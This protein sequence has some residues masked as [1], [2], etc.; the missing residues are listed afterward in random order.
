[1]IISHEHK[2]IFLKVT[3]TAGTSVEIAL[4]QHCGETDVI[5]PISIGDEKLRRDL[6]YPC[7]QNFRMPFHRYSLRD[8]KKLLRKRKRRMRFYNHMPAVE[9]KRIVG[10]KIWDEYFKFCFERNPW[11]RTISQYFFRYRNA[12]SRPTLS[13][14]IASGNLERLKRT[15]IDLYSID[16]RIA[17]DR[18][19]SYE[20]LEQDLEEVCQA[21]P[22]HPGKVVLPRAKGNTRTDKRH[23]REFFSESDREEVAEFFAKEISAF[24][25]EF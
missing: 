21:L 24:G 1:V 3:K 20:R 18:V 14:F 11:D 12:D 19:C 5:T 9:V 10:E 13:E 22:G 6:G 16:G 8:W 7:A 25:Y 17:V 2:F 15:G 4:S 23:Y